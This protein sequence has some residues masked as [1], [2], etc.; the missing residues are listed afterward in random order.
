MNGYLTRC[1]TSRWNGTRGIG[2]VKEHD[3]GE[4]HTVMES[5]QSL[6]DCNGLENRLWVKPYG[7]SNPSL[8][9]I[10]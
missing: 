5:W 8:S 2:K 1:S 10:C 4:S 9:A 3:M 6:A 7:G